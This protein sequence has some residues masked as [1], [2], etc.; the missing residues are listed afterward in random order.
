M[1]ARFGSFRAR[2]MSERAQGG[3]AGGVASNHQDRRGDAGLT[4]RA[5]GIPALAG[6]LASAPRKPAP[7]RD[8][9][10]SASATAAR[11][12]VDTDDMVALRSRN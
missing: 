6:A 12:D 11:Q 9:G 1:G 10:R 3:G 2:T 7:G 5:V 8:H 4:F